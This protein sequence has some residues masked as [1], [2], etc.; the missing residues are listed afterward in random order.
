MRIIT[1]SEVS[2]GRY[3][4]REGPFF[5]GDV[6]YTLPRNPDEFDKIISVVTSTESGMWNAVNGYDRCIVSV[7]L[8]QLCEARYMLT[9]RL[10]H[11][12]AEEMG[13]L[14][15]IRPLTGA[16][17]LSR[18]TF[19][20]NAKGHWR[21]HF[22]DER[23]EVNTVEK[24]EMLFQMGS[25]MLGSWSETRKH[26]AQVWVAG[27]AS[28]FS[29]ECVNKVQ[30]RFLRGM[31][32]TLFVLKPVQPILFNG[33][34]PS[35]DAYPAALK[36]AYYSFAANN[37][38]VAME[39]IVRWNNESELKKWSPDWCI[40][41]IQKMTFDPNIG[42]YPGRYERIRPRLEM[43]YGVLLPQLASDLRRW[44]PDPLSGS[45]PTL[46]ASP[47]GLEGAGPP[48]AANLSKTEPITDPRRRYDIVDIRD[49][50]AGSPI[51]LWNRLMSWLT[52]LFMR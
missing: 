26:H 32:T 6:K 33:D 1:P 34:E 28:V 18:A 7:G 41:A 38:R 20:K 4:D 16:L 2:W 50:D 51:S 45:F 48:R 10:L 36:A 31:M 19:R 21:F 3:R 44:M 46:P 27:L 17:A 39:S 47:I 5:R 12:V 40:G 42:I 11:A 8:I 25:N 22:L 13:A 29:D 37:P 49:V 30:E 52:R 15:V 23:G 14:A 24:Q 9:S 35:I 43:L